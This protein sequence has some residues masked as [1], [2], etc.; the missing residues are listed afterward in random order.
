MFRY[1]P[2]MFVV[3]LAGATPA[4]AITNPTPDSAH[5][6]VGAMAIKSG[7]DWI[8]VCSGSLISPTV[9]VTAGH[10]IAGTIGFR[11]AVTFEQDLIDAAALPP[12]VVSTLITGTGYLDPQFSNHSVW[13]ERHDL[14]VIV[15]NTPVTDRPV[16]I[17][18]TEDLLDRLDAVHL[19]T[20][21]TEFVVV[22]YG[23]SGPDVQANQGDHSKYLTN[24]RNLGEERFLSLKTLLIHAKAN[25]NQGYES[26]CV[27][28]SGGPYYLAVG[29]QEI[30]VGVS[31][32]VNSDCTNGGAYAYRLDTVE[33]RSFLSGFVSLP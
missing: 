14:G 17:L 9:F 27:G 12:S 33:A 32:L 8:G 7:S 28:D 20:S 25:E 26:I 30:I 6:W 15:L 13:D 29:G 31:S 5:T 16:S 10:C 18:P 11:L 24:Q 22:G 2:W 3:L 23:W 4:G 1:R 21:D 19:M